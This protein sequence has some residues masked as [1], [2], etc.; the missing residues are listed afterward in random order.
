MFYRK[1]NHLWCT[2]RLNI[3]PLALS[4]LLFDPVAEVL[5]NC[6]ILMY[7]DDSVI[8]ISAKNIEIIQQTLTNYFKRIADWIEL[9]GLV[10]NMKKGKT[11]SNNYYWYLAPI[12]KRKTNN[13]PFTIVISRSL[14]LPLTSIW[15]SYWTNH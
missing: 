11:E 6:K 13:S 9:N 10:T 2:A 3:R 15:M 14:I 7:A 4:P 12:K 8:F 1:Q 5:E